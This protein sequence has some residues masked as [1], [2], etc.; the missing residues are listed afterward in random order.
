MSDPVTS[1]DGTQIHYESTGS[2]APALVFVHG[3]LGNVRW[4]DAQ[5]DHF[6]ARHQVVTIDLAGHGCSGKTRTDWSIARYG[7][8]VRAVLD[9]IAAPEVVL[10]GHSMSGPNVVAAAAGRREVVGIVLVDT[11]K[12]LD[13]AMPIEQANQIMAMYRSDFPR[14]VNDLLPQYLYSPSTPPE[15]RARLQ[16]EFLA[17]PAEFAVTAIEPLYKS[18]LAALAAAIRVPVRNIVGDLEPVDTE[19]NRK[20]FGDYDVL[21]L[22][23]VGHYPMLEKP[24]EFNAALE[25][26]LRASGRS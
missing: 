20:H 26:A 4:W 1:S 23:A 8:D 17:T 21:R 3:W 9:R 5:R 22:P 14:A 10:V 18:D 16:R 15:V 19:V 6:A 7:D 11:M 25:D 13:R 12:N 24:A 2:G